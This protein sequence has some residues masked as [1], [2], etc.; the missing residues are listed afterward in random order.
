MIIITVMIIIEKKNIK[1]KHRDELQRR[2]ELKQKGLH[3]VKEVIRQRMIAKRGK[4]KDTIIESSNSNKIERLN[5]GKFF[6]VLDNEGMQQSNERPNV[7]ETKAFWSEIWGQEVNHNKEADWVKE[8]RK[9]GENCDKQERPKVTIE[10]VQK[11][12]KSFPN[13]KTPSPD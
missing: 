7:E 1:K 4:S 10:K 5:Q 8:F 13:W 3:T 9:E 6:K 12:L 2:Y 11:K